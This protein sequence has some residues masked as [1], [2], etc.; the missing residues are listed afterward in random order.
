MR[1]DQAVTISDDEIEFRAI[2]AQ[3]PGGQNVNKVASAVHL[4]FNINASSLPQRIKDRLLAIHDSRVTKGGVIIIKAQQSRSQEQNR[5]IAKERL[6]A[7]IHRAALVGKS[8][9]PTKPSR[10]ARARRLD[11]KTKHG[12]VKALRGRVADGD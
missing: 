2:R 6:T 12:R 7:L 8:R 10:A 9:R 5:E 11:K 4:R 1:I 3:G